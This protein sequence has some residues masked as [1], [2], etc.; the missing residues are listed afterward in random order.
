[1]RLSIKFVVGCCLVPLLAGASF[2]A[3]PGA[4]PLIVAAEQGD[5]SAV[6]SLLNDGVDPNVATGDGSTAPFWAAHTGDIEVAR[7]LLANGAEVDRANSFG[8]T[9]LY[10]AALNADGPL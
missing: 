6:S 8:A 9:P 3:S 4:P 2:A 5:Q 10:E 1:M 7:V